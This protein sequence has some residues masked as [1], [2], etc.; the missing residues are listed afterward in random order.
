MIETLTSSSYPIEPLYVPA[1]LIMSGLTP[2]TYPQTLQLQHA[3]LSIPES[4]F[5]IPQSI[6]PHGIRSECVQ[7]FLQYHREAIT[8]AHY[9]RWYDYSKLS[10][11]IIFN[12]AE[13]ADV[14]QH[15]IVAFSALIYSIKENHIRAREIAFIYYSIALQQLRLFLNKPIMDMIDCFVAVATALELSSFDVSYSSEL[16]DFSDFSETFQSVFDILKVRHA[17]CRKSQIRCNY[18][19]ALSAAPF[20]SG[21]YHSKIIAAS[22]HRTSYC[23]LES[24]VKRMFTYDINWL[25]SNIRIFPIANAKHEY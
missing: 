21:L 20:L 8:E 25:S 4:T 7:F 14:L 23:F 2:T 17:F 11:V 9:L 10:T 5:S 16:S 12:L 18:A 6:S 3:P 15:A 13:T 22:L 19:Q 24:G 1:A